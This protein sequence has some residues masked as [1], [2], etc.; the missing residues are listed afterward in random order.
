MFS[1]QNPRAERLL[2]IVA[3]DLDRFLQDDSPCINA[4]VDEVNRGTG[5]ANA[6]CEGLVLRVHPRK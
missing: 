2:G 6:R 4:G 5:P 1:L 3:H